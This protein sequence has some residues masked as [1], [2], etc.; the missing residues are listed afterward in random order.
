MIWPRSLKFEELEPDCCK[1]S[2]K[3]TTCSVWS[4]PRFI[5]LSTLSCQW[6]NPHVCGSGWEQSRRGLVHLDC[7]PIHRPSVAHWKV[8]CPCSFKF[9][10][11]LIDLLCLLLRHKLLKYCGR[12]CALIVHVQSTVSFCCVQPDFC[13]PL[14]LAAGALLKW[15]L[16]AVIVAYKCL[17]GSPYLVWVECPSCHPPCCTMEL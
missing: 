1:T 6:P 2:V 7:S 14:L 9:D 17:R 5:W 15:F 16:L 12:K 4:G 8:G 13:W 11:T 10:F 3:Y